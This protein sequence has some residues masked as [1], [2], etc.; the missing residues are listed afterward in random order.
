[1]RRGAPGAVRG[2][3]PPSTPEQPP[4]FPP[5]ITPVGLNLPFASQLPARGQKVCRTF[6][7]AQLSVLSPQKVD[8]THYFRACTALLRRFPWRRPS[9]LFS[10]GR[11]EVQRTRPQMKTNLP[12]R[13]AAGMGR[14]APAQVALPEAVRRRPSSLEHFVQR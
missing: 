4:Q 13:G 3:R 11:S 14:G 8:S 12:A 6:A 9:V 1:M 5:A 10:D 2:G 7:P